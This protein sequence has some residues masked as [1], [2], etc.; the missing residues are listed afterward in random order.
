MKKKNCV[1]ML[2][3][4]LSLSVPV[5]ANE[6]ALPGESETSIQIEQEMLVVKAHMGVGYL[7]GDSS[8]LV[9]GE[10]GR[11]L[12]ELNWELDDV[13]ML[14][15]GGSI[16]P[17][18]WLTISADFWTR[19]NRGSGTM[20]DYDFLA[21]NYDGYTHW[22]HHDNTDLTQGFMFDLNA[23]FTF[24]TFEETSFSA[25][26]G[27]KYDTWEWEARGGN[28]FYSDYVLFDNVGSFSPDE[29]VITYKQW[30]H[31]PYIGVGF[32]STVGP[33]FFMGRVIASPLVFAGDEDIHHLR[34]LR[35]EEDFDVSSMYGLDLG[36]GYNIT[37]SLAVSAMFRYQKYEEAK[38][39][40]TVTD[41][42]TGEK[43]YFSGDVA[44]IDHSSSTVSLGLQY[45]F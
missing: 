3:A 30:F 41:L 32:H 1:A 40:T 38:G 18:S 36:L 29:K 2:A 10:N 15:V 42:T 37:P 34:N 17:R 5:W 13:L 25:L 23:A 27:Y 22:S 7:N 4:G 20:D 6:A 24:Y 19:L 31:V 43:R 45:R 14:N 21:I 39:D 16:S 12:S 33:V 11:K 28:Y 9:Y 26:V 8:E 44:G 35:F